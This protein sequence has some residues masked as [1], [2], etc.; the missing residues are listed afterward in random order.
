M[1]YMYKYTESMPNGQQCT[2]LET[3]YNDQGRKYTV[4]ESCLDPQISK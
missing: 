3:Y 4:A 1:W 2:Q